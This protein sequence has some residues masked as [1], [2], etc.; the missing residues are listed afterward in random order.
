[1]NEVLG[2]EAAYE[3]VQLDVS[4]ASVGPLL[5]V[6][7]VSATQVRGT[8]AAEVFVAVDIELVAWRLDGDGQL[9]A[10]NATLYDAV[11]ASE[12]VFQ[13]EGPALRS[14]TAEGVVRVLRGDSLYGEST[15]AADEFFSVLSVFPG[16]PSV[17]PPP[18]GDDVSI[19]VPSTGA[20]QLAVDFSWVDDGWQA[21]V[22]LP[23]GGSATLRCEY[24]PT[25]RVWDGPDSFDY[26]G[27]YRLYADAAP[28][29]W[30]PIW[31]INAAMADYLDAEAIRSIEPS[32][33][34]PDPAQ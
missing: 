33:S 6:Q 26:Q 20:A 3:M 14:A 15:D 24:D 10:Q 9:E 28:L 23:K 7:R 32:P 21:E 8:V 2:M 4:P 11:V 34:E 17:D 1:M 12:L 19:P 29:M 30:N 22:A 25:T 16:M 13:R 27:P 5:G 18:V 31:A